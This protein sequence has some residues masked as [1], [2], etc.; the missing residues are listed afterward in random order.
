MCVWMVLGVRESNG[1]QLVYLYKKKTLLKAEV[2]KSCMYGMASMMNFVLKIL[3]SV[4]N[5]SY[6]EI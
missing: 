2:Q 3:A 4:V 6:F 1:R 5:I